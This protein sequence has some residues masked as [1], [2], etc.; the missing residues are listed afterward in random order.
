[1]SR[2]NSSTIRPRPA[3][4]KPRKYA[5]A[6]FWHELDTPRRWL[7]F[8]LHAAFWVRSEATSQR[9]VPSAASPMTNTTLRRIYEEYSCRR[10]P[11]C[12]CEMTNQA[13]DRSP[14]HMARARATHEAALSA[15]DTSLRVPLTVG[16]LPFVQRRVVTSPRHRSTRCR[17]YAGRHHARGSDIRRRALH[18]AGHS[19]SRGA[20][21]PP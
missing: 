20:H 4:T 21:L 3:T 5:K 10:R 14:V 11:Q 8:A 19:G 12:R 18:H 2:V 9:P 6:T 15:V 7:E 17:T 13:M 16:S 1:M